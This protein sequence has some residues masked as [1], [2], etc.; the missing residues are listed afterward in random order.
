MKVIVK[1][2]A[3]LRNYGPEYQELEVPETA[4]LGDAI[5]LLKLPDKIPLL[6][7][8]NGEFADV[9]RQLKEGDEIAL[10]PPI[11]GGS[12]SII[13]RCEKHRYSAA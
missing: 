8:I 5:A 7:I 10:F 4:L 11:A 6:K 9:K 3:N 2:F 12:I 13:R 1:L